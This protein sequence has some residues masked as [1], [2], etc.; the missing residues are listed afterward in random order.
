MFKKIILVTLVGITIDFFYGDKATD[1]ILNLFNVAFYSNKIP[2][3][4]NKEKLF[5]KEDLKLYNG[6]EKPEL[7]LVILGNVFDVSKGAEHYGPNKQYNVF[8]G[9]IIYPCLIWH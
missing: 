4:R 9:M 2:Y 5:T 1:I 8:V 3:K 7:Y 6:L